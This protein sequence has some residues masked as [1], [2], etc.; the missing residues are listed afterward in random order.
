VVDRQ[1]HQVGIARRAL[2]LRVADLPREHDGGEDRRRQ[3]DLPQ[4]RPPLRRERH[5]EQDEPGNP[6]QLRTHQAQRAEQQAREGGLPTRATGC[7][8]VQCAR[9]KASTSVVDSASVNG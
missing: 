5:H 4:V 8:C 7:R 6:L 3:C 9:T 2:D 1:H